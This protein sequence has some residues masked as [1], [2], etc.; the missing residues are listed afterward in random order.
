MTNLHVSLISFPQQQLIVLIVYT[1][2]VDVKAG[3]LVANVSTTQLTCQNG[4]TNL[5]PSAMI[6]LKVGILF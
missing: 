2:M 1:M 6:T 5:V 3:Q 4:A